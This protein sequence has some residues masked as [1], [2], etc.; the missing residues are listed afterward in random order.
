MMLAALGMHNES[1][2]LRFNDARTMTQ[3]ALPDMS[4]R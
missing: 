3:C 2:S 4:L 1:T